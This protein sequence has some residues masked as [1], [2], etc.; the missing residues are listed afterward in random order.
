MTTKQSVEARIKQ[1]S[2]EAD[3]VPTRAEIEELEHLFGLQDKKPCQLEL[4]DDEEA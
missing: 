3:H 2:Q 4:F 1:I